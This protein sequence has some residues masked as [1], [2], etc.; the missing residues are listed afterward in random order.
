MG[1]LSA[2]SQSFLECAFDP[3]ASAQMGASPEST[4]R[5]L[6]RSQD[7]FDASTK[8]FQSCQWLSESSRVA[9]SDAAQVG[10]FDESPP[11]SVK[12][13]P[14]RPGEPEEQVDLSHSDMSARRRGSR[15]SC[16]GYSENVNLKKQEA[17]L[18]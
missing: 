2:A 18:H 10:S 12:R 11:G 16:G 4:S 9:T 3:D 14:R 5:G 8:I 7:D 13:G 17:D 1:M 6:T 15:H